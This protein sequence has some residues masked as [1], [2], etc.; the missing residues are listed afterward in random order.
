[1]EIQNHTMTHSDFG[2]QRI[3]KQDLT[4][5]ERVYAALLRGPYSQKILRTPFLSGLMDPDVHTVAASLHYLALAGCNIAS[6]GA[7]GASKQKVL[8]EVCPQIR[9][10]AI[11]LMHADDADVQALADIID[12]SQ[13]LGLQVVAL[14]N[15]PGMP[16]FQPQKIK[17]QRSRWRAE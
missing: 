4:D 5:W 12:K 17:E 15:L 3:T 13:S 11:I 2:K 9:P 8:D 1:M 7:Y 10:G 14:R 6:S 16:H